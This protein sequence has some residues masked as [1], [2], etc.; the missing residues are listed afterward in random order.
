MQLMSSESGSTRISSRDKQVRSV[1]VLSPEER[2]QLLEVWNATDHEVPETTLPELFEAQVART[3]AAI[4]AVYEGVSLSYTELNARANQLARCLIGQGVGPESIVALALSRSLEMVVGL[5]GILKAGGAYLPL[6]PNYPD[7]RLALMIEDARPVCLL[8]MGEVPVSIADSTMVL[9]LN[10]GTTQ[11]A[12]ASH[13]T[14]NLSDTD[15]LNP[16]LADHP[17]YVIYTSGSTGNPKGV[18]GTHRVAVARLQWD[19][20]GL[21]ADDEVYCQKT[22]LNFIDHIWEIFM[23]LLRGQR[24]V[25]ISDAVLRDPKELIAALAANDVTRLMLVPSLLEALLEQPIDLQKCLPKLRYW[26]SSGEP[27]PSRLAEHFR[28][29]L[30]NALLLNVYGTSEFWDATYYDTKH[31]AGRYG[32]PIGRPIWNMRVYILDGGLQPVPVG[33][34]GELY[35]AGSGLA[36]GYLRQPGLTS[37]RFIANPYDLPGGRMYRTG[38][39]ARWRSDGVLEFLGRADQQVK[40]RG[41]RIELGEIEAVLGRHPDVE[42]A[43]VIVR[44]DTP[45]DKRLVAYVVATPDKVMDRAALR[46]HVTGQLPEYIVP[47]AI[48]VLERLPLTPNGKLD[49]RALLAP[50]FAVGVNSRTPRTLE[51]KILSG[52]FAEV[53]G[54]ERVGIDDNFFELGGHSLLVMR[55]IRRIQSTMSIEL[56]VRMLFEAP[57]VAELGEA[58]SREPCLASSRT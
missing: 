1:E 2:H 55:L 31:G 44:E 33:V 23:P 54:I 40:L 21:E 57:T 51:E 48:M 53:L 8:T 50:D 39:L 29:R 16:L 6:D 10:E 36:R 9:R 58:L 35:V 3:P 37:E 56:P 13:T 15:R 27:L 7:N 52:L 26:E 41:V 17:A 46:S 22:T 28:E 5:L 11:A 34:G 20:Q 19:M 38:D 18:V 32:I 43:V 4:A 47:T 24:T 45:G 12:L 30:P 14:S 42:Q 25:L 49:R